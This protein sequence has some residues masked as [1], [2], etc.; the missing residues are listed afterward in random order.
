MTARCHSDNALSLYHEVK[1]M[2]LKDGDLIMTTWRGIC[3]G[4]RIIMARP[5]KI[6]GDFPAINSYNQDMQLILAAIVAAGVNDVQTPY[7]ACLPPQYTLQEVRA[8]RLKPTRNAYVPNTFAG[9]VGTNANAATVANDAAAITYRTALAGRS[10]V[11]TTHVGPMPDA[12]SAAGL[13]T[14]A[15]RALLSALGTVLT[16]SF[17]PPTSGSLVVPV[18]WNRKLNTTEFITNFR[19]GDAS[20]VQRRRTVGIGE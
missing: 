3:F 5:Y 8:Q 2:A 20:R 18:I 11:A 9:A 4:Q 13:I 17:V 15:Q 16:T 10:Q 6:S 19:L 7:L 1:T 12:A 14:A